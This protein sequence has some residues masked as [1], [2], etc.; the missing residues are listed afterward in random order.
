MP[1]LVSAVVGP[2][3]MAPRSPNV[4]P[5][6]MVAG[7]L[8]LIEMV[9]AE[10][11][12]DWVLDGVELALSVLLL[13]EELLAPPVLAAAPAR[14]VLS[15]SSLTQVS[16]MQSSLVRTRFAKKSPTPFAASTR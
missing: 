4:S 14:S 11:S 2:V 1:R 8:P 12:S 7:L 9:G 5:T 13:D 10:P 6:F 16:F 3:M 15:C